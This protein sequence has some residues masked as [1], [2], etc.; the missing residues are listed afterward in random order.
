MWQ[1][2][3]CKGAESDDLWVYGKVGLTLDQEKGRTEG[4][5]KDQG[6]SG[7]GQ[8]T[9]QQT[10]NITHTQNN[11]MLLDDWRWDWSVAPAWKFQDNCVYV[12]PPPP[13]PAPLWPF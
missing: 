11:R 5:E 7:A 12:M 10:P 13:P 2:F 8:T 3:L 4:G 6:G 1:P 9:T